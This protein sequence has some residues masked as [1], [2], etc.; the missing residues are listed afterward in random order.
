MGAG[1]A[2]PSPFK[3]PRE[4]ELWFVWI[5]GK[6]P[7]HLN[8]PKVHHTLPPHPL[9]THPS[10][11]RNPREC[12]Q[13]KT[14]NTMVFKIFSIMPTAATHTST[15][16]NPRE[17]SQWKTVNTMLFKIFSIMPTAAPFLDYVIPG[18]Y[19]KQIPP[20]PWASAFATSTAQAPAM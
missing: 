1:G 13:W 7:E 14:V 9:S 20:W 12:S 2:P 18:I 3:A 17:G 8:S 15:S 19:D 6:I 10:T 16:R 4:S 11:S 5:G